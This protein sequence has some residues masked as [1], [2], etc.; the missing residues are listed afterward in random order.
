M[1]QITVRQVSDH[2]V[3][4]AKSLA[5]KRGVAMNAIFVEAL[6]KGLGLDAENMTNGLEKFA[7][8][9]DFGPGWESRMAEVSQIDPGD[10]Q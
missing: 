4:E 9:S 8:D 2:C 6:E 1:K 10:W 3:A 5:R 7:G